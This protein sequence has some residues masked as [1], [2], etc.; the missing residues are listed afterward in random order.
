MYKLK[1]KRVDDFIVDN[2][3]KIQIIG[4]KQFLWL[5]ANDC[6]V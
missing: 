2:V 6:N 5:F 3:F 1:K 4:T